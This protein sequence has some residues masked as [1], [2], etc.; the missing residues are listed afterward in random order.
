MTAPAHHDPAAGTATEDRGITAAD[1]TADRLTPA[2]AA[3]L[4]PTIN[5][6]VHDDRRRPTFRP[7]TTGPGLRWAI[8][9]TVTFEPST[10]RVDLYVRR[11]VPPADRERLHRHALSV[12][13]GRL[14]ELDATAGP[15]P[16]TPRR[17]GTDGRTVTTRELATMWPAG[18][19]AE[20]L[21]A[22]DLGR[23]DSKSRKGRR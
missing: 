1:L 21:A 4:F 19:V 14:H 2:R 18:A 3:D 12:A 22:H 8:C 10:G 7:C 20:H 16:W 15:S 9:G 17:Q 13:L 5:V 6:H 23:P 11:D